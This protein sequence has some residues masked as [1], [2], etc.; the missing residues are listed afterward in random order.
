MLQYDVNPALAAAQSMS[1]LHKTYSGSWHATS[2]DA[3]ATEQTESHPHIRKGLCSGLIYR[4]QWRLHFANEMCKFPSRANLLDW[5]CF[6][7]HEKKRENH[8]KE[9]F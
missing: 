6:D 9:K 8:Q 1:I 5:T 3:H 4:M 2:T 7:K